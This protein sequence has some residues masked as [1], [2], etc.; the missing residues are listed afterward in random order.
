MCVCLAAVSDADNFHISERSASQRRSVVIDSQPGRDGPIRLARL[1]PA[2]ERKPSPAVAT[3]SG[4]RLLPRGARS[5][6]QHG[7]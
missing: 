2:A 5:D 1:D 6:A 4:P 7:R 3:V